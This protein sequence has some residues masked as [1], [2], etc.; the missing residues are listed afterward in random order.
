MCE[1]FQM[2]CTAESAYCC[3][4]SLQILSSRIHPI[5]LRTI[6]D[7]CG[8]FLH[9]LIA[10]L[11][12]CVSLIYSMFE[13]EGGGSYYT[14]CFYCNLEIDHCCVLCVRYGTDWTVFT[15][16]SQC[17][18]FGFASGAVMLPGSTSGSFSHKYGSGSDSISFQ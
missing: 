13:G 18:G 1:F 8:F 15:C 16:F 14:N 6:W 12:L 7:L 9:Y 10:S 3:H 2:Q 5:N 11:Q 4:F 17:C